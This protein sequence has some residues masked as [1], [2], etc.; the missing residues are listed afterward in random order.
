MLIEALIHHEFE[1]ASHA[2]QGFSMQDLFFPCLPL[3]FSVV[4]IIPVCSDD[5]SLELEPR[6]DHLSTFPPERSASVSKADKTI[7]MASAQDL[8]CGGQ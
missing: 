6:P 1:V 5:N 3:S 7:L 8:R 2:V 4:S